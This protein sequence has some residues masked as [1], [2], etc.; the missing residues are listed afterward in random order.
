MKKQFSKT[1]PKCKVTFSL[2]KELVGDAK[3]VVVLGE[4]NEWDHTGIPLKKGKQSFST[5]IELE[6]GRDYEF[7]YLVDGVKW[8]N[9]S[10][11]DAYVP[12]PF[13][14]IQNSL[15]TV[16]QKDDDFKKIEGIGPK[17]DKILKEKGIKTFQDL[18]I[19]P[20][21]IIGQILE[22]QGKRY[23][24][25]DPTTWPEQARLASEGKWE[26]LKKWQNKLDG[27]K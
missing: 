3:K 14:G 25:H 16:P 27:G 19:T 26:E 17:I 1:T 12:S 20:A 2:P 8:Y 4:F 7:R 10:F 18:S 21:D 23:S 24:M 5:S 13:S 6:T 22:E 11:A 15:V 9:D